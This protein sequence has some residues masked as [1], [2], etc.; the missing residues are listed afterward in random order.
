MNK[1]N[2]NKKIKQIS[3]MNISGEDK[4]ELEEE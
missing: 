1:T 3:N 2:E 4:E